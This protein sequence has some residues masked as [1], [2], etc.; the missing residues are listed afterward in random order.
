M[1]L[2]KPFCFLKGPY[3][4][5]K[6][7]N[8]VDRF[9]KCLQVLRLIIAMRPTASRGSILYESFPNVTR[10]CMESTNGNNLFVRRTKRTLRTVCRRL[11]RHVAHSRLVRVRF[12]SS[13]KS[14]QS[15]AATHVEC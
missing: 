3:F 10:N 1:K 14:P 15:L 4:V 6:G 13:D 11:P 7:K 9:C 12:A 5:A 8:I 2:K